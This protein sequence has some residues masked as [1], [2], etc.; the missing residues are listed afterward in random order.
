MR[1]PIALVTG[2]VIG[3]LVSGTSALAYWS[4]N[5]TG[6]GEGQATVSQGNN[7]PIVIVQTAN[8][9]GL[10]P[11]KSVTLVGTFNN[12]NSGYDSGKVT[13]RT[14]TASIS[15]VKGQGCSAADFT[16][17]GAT[18]PVNAVIA[19]GTGVGH[20]GGAVLTMVNSSRDQSACHGA[21]VNIHYVSN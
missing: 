8:T 15:G 4:N 13:V 18:M 20:W 12:P 9:S 3:A 21:T 2:V 7:K 6:S 5:S 19:G 16:L 17:T 10:I 11:G 1:T 14:V